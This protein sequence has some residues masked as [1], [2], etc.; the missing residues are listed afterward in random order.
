MIVFI[1]ITIT[2]KINTKED[3]KAL[4]KLSNDRLV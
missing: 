1:D 2:K 3:G 4:L